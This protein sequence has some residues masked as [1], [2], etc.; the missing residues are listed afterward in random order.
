MNPQ[1][2]ITD[3]YIRILTA[4]R[5]KNEEFNREV[6]TGLRSEIEE[7]LNHMDEEEDRE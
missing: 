7:L 1:E 3:L 4:M 5:G 2:V 6:L